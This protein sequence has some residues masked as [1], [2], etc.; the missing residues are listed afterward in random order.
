[1]DYCTVVCMGG[2][3]LGCICP[4]FF[5]CIKSPVGFLVYPEVS[6][7]HV[8][9]RTNGC[10]V[11]VLMHFLDYNMCVI[12]VYPSIVSQRMGSK[13]VDDNLALWLVF[14]YLSEIA[15]IGANIFQRKPALPT[16]VWE[17]VVEAKVYSG[18]GLLLQE[19]LSKFWSKDVCSIKLYKHILKLVL[20]RHMIFLVSKGCL[21]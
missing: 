6:L 4:C 8:L 21:V 10:Q 11:V 20:N 14:I 15:R 7:A 1:M 12:K 13:V 5:F 3:L 17:G 2:W 19:L 9:S 16:L 18:K